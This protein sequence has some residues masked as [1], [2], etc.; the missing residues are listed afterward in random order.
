MLLS[1]LD[2]MSAMEYNGV[3]L[4]VV[5]KFLE[6]GFVIQFADDLFSSWT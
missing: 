2:G 1:R 4:K 6:V 5:E 3:I